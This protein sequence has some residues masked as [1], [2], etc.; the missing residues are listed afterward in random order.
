MAELRSNADEMASRFCQ[1]GAFLSA[2]KNRLAERGSQQERKSKVI[3][4]V[5]GTAM[6]AGDR[7]KMDKLRKQSEVRA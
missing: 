1:Y 4:S 3:A 7:V 2:E 5:Y 6:R